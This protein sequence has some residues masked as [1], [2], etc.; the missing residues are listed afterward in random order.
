MDRGG[1]GKHTC[2][3]KEVIFFFYNAIFDFLG[4]CF[5]TADFKRKNWKDYFI[6]SFY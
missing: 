3:C 2:Y 6:N 5:T 4:R 1:E